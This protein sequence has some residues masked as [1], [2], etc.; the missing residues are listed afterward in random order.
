MT[1]ADDVDDDNRLLRSTV[2][3]TANSILIARL[4]VEQ[5]TEAYLAEA[6][7]LSHTGS[8][9]WRVSTGEIVWSEETFRIFQYDPAAAPTVEL[10]L[11]R[12]HPQDSARVKRTIEVAAREGKDFDLEHRLLMPD[13]S[14][15]HVQVV[16]RAATDE[17][18]GLEFIGA[19][20][21]VTVAKRAELLMTR[22]KRLLEMIA[23]G[24]SRALILDGLCR[25]FEE[26]AAGALSSIL[27]LDP[28]A[29]CLRHGAAPSLPAAYSQAINGIAIGPSVGSCGTAAYRAEPVIVSDISTDPL[30]AEFR[31]LALSHGLRACWSTPIQSSDGRV[32][33]TF[34][35]YYH[36]PR[37]PTQHEQDVIEQIT[38][39]A[40]IALERAQAEE[41]L[42]QAQAELAHVARVTTLGE[43]AA[44]IAH[45][46][47]QPLS[48]V[49]INA[50]ASLRFLSGPYQ[51][52]EE[53]RDGLQA[54][55]R[56]GQRASDVI[57]R[58][59][60]LARRATAEKGP[61]DINEV[62]RDVIALADGEARRTRA[63]LRTEV[64]RDLPRIVADRVQLQQVV[65]NLLLNGL[66]AMH[67][68]VDRP[69]DLV[70]TTERE[71]IDRVHVAVRDS[72][73]GIDPQ[74][75]HRLFEA[76]Y[77]TKPNG[78]GM[79]LS[80]SRSIVEQHGGRLWAEPK[81]GPGTTFH[82]TV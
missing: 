53:V 23:R 80:I 65:L 75:A 69:R 34:A 71:A 70:I 32:L 31:D 24:D 7:R 48:G 18:Q 59:R 36:E 39:L 30:W 54:I 19:V 63:T 46:V 42:R 25:L 66:D 28:F 9:G 10:V 76:F 3:Q 16:A 40:S 21:D 64:T 13:G 49:V 72:G 68:V 15:K 17:S 2:L 26:S 55:A 14:V 37:S 79:G 12:T 33:G 45:E 50:T 61:V 29:G 4:R 78:M 74:L 51:N 41:A 35:I 47:D 82:F 43:M 60:A 52:L 58:I 77:T 22:E 56:D 11:Q 8:F 44:S 20:M 73:T 38:H 5:R 6:Q 81:D 62:V 67:D 27:L 1:P 57:G